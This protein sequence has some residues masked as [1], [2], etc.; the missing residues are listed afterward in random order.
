MPAPPK[1]KQSSVPTT[2]MG[3]VLRFGLLSGELALST[4]IGTARQWSSGKP[5]DLAAAVLTSS[6]AELLARRLASLPVVIWLASFA[7]DAKQVAYW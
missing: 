2:R 3:R 7:A 1:R 6:N 4:A 5:L